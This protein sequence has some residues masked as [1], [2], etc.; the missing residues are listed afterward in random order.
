MKIYDEA[1]NLA[2]AIKESEEYKA[3]KSLHDE[4]NSIDSVKLELQEFQKQ[5]IVLQKRQLAGEMLTEEDLIEAQKIY[6]ELIKNDIVANFFD[7]ERKLNLV[8]ADVSKI[9]GE[10]MDFK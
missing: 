1:N 6:D 8:M 9:L 3:Y 4:I 5:Q 7:A 10:V 2:K